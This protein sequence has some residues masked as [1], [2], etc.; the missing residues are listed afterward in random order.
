MTEIIERKL[1]PE[2]IAER[3]EW[4]AGQHQRDIDAVKVARHSAYAAPGGSDAIYMKYT[5]G[6]ATMEQYLAMV[7]TIDDAHPYPEAP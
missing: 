7:K 4:E 2:E 1:T 5:R 6:E 3:A